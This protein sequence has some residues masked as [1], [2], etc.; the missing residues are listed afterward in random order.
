VAGPPVMVDAVSGVLQGKG[1]AQRDIH[2]DAFHN[3][4]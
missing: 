1:M 3:Q 2:A 4:P